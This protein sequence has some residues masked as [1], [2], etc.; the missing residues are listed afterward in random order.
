MAMNFRISTGRKDADLIVLRLSGDFDGS[1]AW[2]L[3][4]VMSAYTGKKT[5]MEVDTS[6]LKTLVPFGKSTWMT[7]GT[8]LIRSFSHF[9]FTGRKAD[10]LNDVERVSNRKAD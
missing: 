6:G 3:I 1:S 7:H 2:E 4:N 10:D 9:S 5:A 8:P